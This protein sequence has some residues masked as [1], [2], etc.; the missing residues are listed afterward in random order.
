M[1]PWIGACAEHPG[2]PR[3][4]TEPRPAMCLKYDVTPRVLGRDRIT[5]LQQTLLKQD[6]YIP[7]L[8]NEDPTRRS[9]NCQVTASSYAK[10]EVFGRENVHGDE[11]HPSTCRV[12][13]M[14]P[15]GIH[16]ELKT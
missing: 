2:H 11:I 3:P 13:V 1:W 8:P 12:A 5:E 9:P 16:R 6:Q 4:A 10:Y 7:N 14:F 15:R